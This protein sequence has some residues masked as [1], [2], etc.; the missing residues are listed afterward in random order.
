MSFDGKYEKKIEKLY[1]IKKQRHETIEIE[2][3]GILFS[4][5]AFA[6]KKKYVICVELQDSML[7]GFVKDYNKKTICIEEITEF[8]ECDGECVIQM[9]KI[10]IVSV[11]TDDEQDILLLMNK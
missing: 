2:D 10:N 9:E 7:S 4:I 5:L 6:K 3:K 8:G 1:R 11:D